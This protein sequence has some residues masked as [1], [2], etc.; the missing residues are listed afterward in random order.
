[1][2]QAPGKEG[3]LTMLD[4]PCPIDYK[5]I[6]EA[7]EWADGTNARRPWRIEF[8][9]TFAQLVSAIS[10]GERCRVLELG[11]GPGFLAEALLSSHPRIDYV[12]LDNSPA[13]HFLARERL[14]ENAPHATL[15]ERSFKDGDWSAGLGTFDFVVTNQ[16]VHE[17]RHKRHAKGLHEQVLQVLNPSGVYLVCDHFLGE[18]AMTNAELYMTPEEQ[19]EAI[20]SAG[21]STIEVVLQKG[22]L[23]LHKAT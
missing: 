20:R 22:D 2:A 7:R 15:I 16:A 13:M 9:S 5:Q 12:G 21:F 1:L 23:I 6:A 3:T 18:G 4:V 14:G 11:S 17:L 8:F 19:R 10:K